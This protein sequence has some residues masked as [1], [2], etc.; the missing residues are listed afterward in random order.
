MRKLL[1]RSIFASM[2]AAVA[3]LA[4]PPAVLAQNSSRPNFSGIWRRTGP[5]ANVNFG[6]GAPPLQAWA[7]AIYDENRVGIDNVEEAGLDDVDPTLYCMPHGIPR[8]LASNQPFEI[9]QTPEVL[10]ALFES[11][12]MQRRIYLDG[13]KFPENY[14]PTYMG[15]STGHFDGDTLVAETAAISDLTWLDT[16]GAPHSEALKITERMRRTG[17]DK[18]EIAFRFEDPKAFTRP[19][20]DTLGYQLKPDWSI[21]E[22][23]GYCDDKFRDNYSKKIYKGNTGWQSPSPEQAKGQ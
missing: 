17:P 23:I 16:S 19:I 3:G 8:V 21:M 15:F 6:K 1:V 10:Y 4:I 12:Q 18:M 20:Q 5:A 2:F 9:I 22:N 7:K 11:Q 13:R 14:P